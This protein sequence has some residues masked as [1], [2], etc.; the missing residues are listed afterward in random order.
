MSTNSEHIVKHLHR[1]NFEW[2]DIVNGPIISFLCYVQMPAEAE[3]KAAELSLTTAKDMRY[4]GVEA[5]PDGT[6]ISPCSTPKPA[7]IVVDAVLDAKKGMKAD[8][9]V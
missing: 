3:A 4:L 7:M 8:A 6:V 9:R 2:P 1:L 5:L